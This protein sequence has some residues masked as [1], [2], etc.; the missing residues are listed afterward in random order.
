MSREDGAQFGEAIAINALDARCA[1]SRAIIGF[2]AQ[3]SVER[4]W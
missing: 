4:R 3:I 1:V 2:S